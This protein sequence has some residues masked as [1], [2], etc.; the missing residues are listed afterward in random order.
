MTKTLPLIVSTLG[1]VLTGCG[2][3]HGTAPDAAPPV[4]APSGP[5]RAVVVAGGPGH[6]G[7]LATL[8]PTS[9]PAT[10][11]VV[12]NAEPAM[13]IGEDP[14]LRHFS[15]ELFIVNRSDGNVTILND[16]TLTFE[17]QLAT[18]AGTN[19]RDVAVTGQKLYVATFGGKGLVMLTRGQAAVTTIDLS[20][21]DPDGKP[22]CNSVYLAGSNLYVSCGLLDDTNNFVPRG[23]GKVY[24]VDT[25]TNAIKTTLTLSTKNPI[26]V[27]EQ[28]PTGAQHNPGDLLIPTVGVADGSGCVERITTGATPAPAGC[29]MTNTDLMGYA[30]RIAFQIDVS[31][32]LGI[33]WIATATTP[34]KAELHAYDIPSSALWPGPLN[35]TG[36]TISD[37]AV[38]PHGEVV[39]ADTT[40]DASGL[41]VYNNAAELTKAVLP[42]GLPPSSPHGIV[43][44]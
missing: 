16:Q 8:D 9:D 7:V 25:A 32:G 19:P 31:E 28:I 4:D 12:M 43:C 42:I 10:L 6:P 35:A 15:G 18:G 14:I 29:M 22:N 34:P 21:D 11:A 40:T 3:K 26:G 5:P 20:Q 39:I 17:E 30:S 2:D 36:E 1:F 38:C 27:F 33:T 24:I 37:L 44:Y 41:R 23:P 13:A